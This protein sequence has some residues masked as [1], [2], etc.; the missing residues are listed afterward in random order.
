MKFNNRKVVCKIV[1]IENKDI[2]YQYN[3]LMRLKKLNY[4]YNRRFLEKGGR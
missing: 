1:I 4:K 2:N 3:S